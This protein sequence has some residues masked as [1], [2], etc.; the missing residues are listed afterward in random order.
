MKTIVLFI[1]LIY[2]LSIQC[3]EI[4]SIRSS[5]RIL[6]RNDIDFENSKN[7]ISSSNL[8]RKKP[9][10]FTS[11][12]FMKQSSF[13]AAD[14]EK[15]KKK[16]FFFMFRNSSNK[17]DGAKKNETISSSN[18]EESL[19]N[20][21]SEFNKFVEDNVEETIQEIEQDN[22][23]TWNNKTDLSE[24]A[25]ETVTL[26]APTS[27]NSTTSKRKKR[28]AF[29][30]IK[31]RFLTTISIIVCLFLAAPAPKRFSLQEIKDREKNF[32]TSILENKE[33]SKKSDQRAAAEKKMMVPTSSSL[34]RVSS[35]SSFVADAVRK[36]GPSVVRIDTESY[37]SGSSSSLNFFDLFG[38]EDSFDDNTDEE[39]MIR[40]GQG[41]GII[42]SQDGF[43]LTNAHVVDGA[44]RV[45]VTLTDGRKFVA[46]VKGVDEMVDIAVLQ[47]LENSPWGG[48]APWGNSN[49]NNQQTPEQKSSSN[50]FQ[51]NALPVP[52][53]GNSDSLQVGEFVIAVGNPAGLDNSVTMG[54]VSSLKRS[55]EEIGLPGKK[56]T[57]IQTDAAV[58]PGN[59]GGPLVNE[60]GEIIG[61]NTCIR[62]N[63][64]GIAFAIPVNK[65]KDIMYQL[66]AGQ[67][68]KHGYIGVVMMTITP[69]FARQNNNDP[70]SP[71][72][73]IP[74]VNGVMIERIL[75]DTP[76]AHCGLRRFD[77]ILEIDAAPVTNAAEAAGVVDTAPV[78]KDLN[79]KVLRGGRHLT[80]SVKPDDL[81]E[82][83]RQR[84]RE[85]KERLSPRPPNGNGRIFV[86]P[87]P[88][89]P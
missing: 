56:V 49:D 55:S 10:A 30:S 64:E 63:M 86:L 3:I 83:L 43:V 39:Q 66:A 88:S 44:N 18:I 79:L 15:R 7:I 37:V 47:I 26:V 78:G 87:F 74:E 80:V 35:S 40:S 1:E 20:M 34:S 8:I 12:L 71:V 48:Y 42:F 68:I 59:S 23:S 27:T 45:Y 61:I 33:S 21:K 4:S 75:Q 32:L 6:M 50:S 19:P 65:A 2:V 69:D 72:G 52:V 29:L 53:F 36:I 85:K 89:N 17:D 38:G 16:S 57:F 67:N 84:K 54:I 9:T 62:A 11:P 51:G 22:Y 31:R 41:S 13:Y 73:I 82:K 77:V 5:R 60:L 70:N 25:A 14:D 46:E 76:A 58:N 28:F 81:S 24:A